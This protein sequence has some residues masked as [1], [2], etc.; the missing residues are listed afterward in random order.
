VNVNTRKA[1]VA[2]VGVVCLTVLLMF[3]KMDQQTGSVG[4]VGIVMYIIGNGVAAATG[5]DVD[6]IVR[7][8]RS[9]DERSDD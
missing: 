3:D 5:K 9:R 1:L 4:I 2:S 6:P 8:K 7:R